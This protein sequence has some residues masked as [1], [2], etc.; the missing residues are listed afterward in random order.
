MTQDI[1][2]AP[3]AGT[4]FFTN[5][6]CE[7]FPCHEGVPIEQFNCLLCYCPLYTL[8]SKCGG[9]YSYTEEGRKDC[10]ACILPHYGE[11]GVQNVWDH[12][13]ELAAL[14]SK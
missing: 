8:G 13:E 4:N 3:A 1:S 14:A 12:Y 2:Q 9:K 11:R 7:Y 5:T 6:A 10:S